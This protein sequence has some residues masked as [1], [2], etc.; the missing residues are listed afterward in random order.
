MAA[1]NPTAVRSRS[2]DMAFE[3]SGNLKEREHAVAF[4]I[5]RYR[6]IL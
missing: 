6:N 4:D 3:E 2:C 1:S 5:F